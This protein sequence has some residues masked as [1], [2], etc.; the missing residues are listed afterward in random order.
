MII[1]KLNFAEIVNFHGEKTK[2]FFIKWFKL[3]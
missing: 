2:G 3:F 1:L